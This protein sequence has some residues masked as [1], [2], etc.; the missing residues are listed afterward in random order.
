[1]KETLIQSLEDVAR[2][3][4]KIG[5]D[6]TGIDKLQAIMTEAKEKACVVQHV[7][8][9]AAIKHQSFKQATSTALMTLAV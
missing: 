6:K 7:I 3:V 8:A 4:V 1:M 2:D 9:I 5:A